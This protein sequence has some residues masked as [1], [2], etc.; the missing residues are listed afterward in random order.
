MDEINDFHN[1]NVTRKQDAEL[2]LAVCAKIAPSLHAFVTILNS[3][4][5]P[6]RASEPNFRHIIRAKANEMRKVLFS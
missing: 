1:R 3:A 4:R 6:D 2:S 5:L